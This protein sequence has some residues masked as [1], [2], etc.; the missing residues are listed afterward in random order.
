MPV[1]SIV[2][3]AYLYLVKRIFTGTLFVYLKRENKR[4]RNM[5]TID[6][7]KCFKQVDEKNIITKLYD[8]T[9]YITDME[10]QDTD[11]DVLEHVYELA[12]DAL[13]YLL[14]VEVI[15]ALSTIIV[16][17]EKIE[18]PHIAEEDDI[19]ELLEANGVVIDYLEEKGA[20]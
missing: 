1:C 3:Q 5:M 14:P 18:A 10:F 17:L 2:Y 6:I 8:M 7:E 4:Y 9:G 11:A 19:T 16:E 15:G 20:L 12:K 13:D